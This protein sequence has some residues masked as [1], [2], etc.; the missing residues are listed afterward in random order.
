ML[1]MFLGKICVSIPS[2]VQQMTYENILEEG[3]TVRNMQ[4]LLSTMFSA[5][6][7]I[8][9]IYTYDFPRFTLRCCHE[10]EVE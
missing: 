3:L 1:Q 7:K 5:L 2:Q 10:R 8:M 9:L 6:I 4:Y